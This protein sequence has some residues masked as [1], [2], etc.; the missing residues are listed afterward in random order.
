[1]TWVPLSLTIWAWSP[2]VLRPLHPG[3]QPV[4]LAPRDSVGDPRLWLAALPSA[5]D[6]GYERSVRHIPSVDASAFDLS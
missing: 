4:L 5:L 3:Y 6:F 1:V 2:G